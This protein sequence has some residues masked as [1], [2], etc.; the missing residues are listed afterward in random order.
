[1]KA[2]VYRRYGG[3][4]VLEYADVQD[5]KLSQPACWCAFGRPHSIRRTICCRP[6]WA[7]AKPTPGSR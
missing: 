3:P 7:R 1:M 2:V 5:P 6:G 4:E